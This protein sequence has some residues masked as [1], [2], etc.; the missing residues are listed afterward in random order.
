MTLCGG[1]SSTT[2]NYSYMDANIRWDTT[3]YKFIQYDSVWSQTE[4]Y[5]P[6]TSDIIVAMR[7]GG[8]PELPSIMYDGG[9][10]VLVAGSTTTDA[11]A[12]DT[13][14]RL[15]YDA[16]LK[17]HTTARLAIRGNANIE[18]LWV[19]NGELMRKAYKV[20]CAY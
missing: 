5:Y 13:I 16:R 7:Q 11:Y 2:T 12:Y 14:G 1:N 20:G 4:T 18:F 3:Y 19:E 17:P 9:C 10:I 8:K 6:E 15:I